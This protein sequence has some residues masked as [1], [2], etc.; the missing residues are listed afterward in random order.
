MEANENYIPD[1]VPSQA[2]K[3]QIEGVDKE[4]QQDEIF[5]DNQQSAT[6]MSWEVKMNPRSYAT[7]KSCKVKMKVNTK[8]RSWNT[9]MKRC[10]IQT[11][12]FSQKIMRF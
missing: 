8:A 1:S 7:M 5:H 3:M 2:Y 12:R 10:F 4:L 9:K 11:N 6:M